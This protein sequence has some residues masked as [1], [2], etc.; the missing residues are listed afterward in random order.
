MMRVLVSACLLGDRVRYS[1]GDAKTDSPVLDRWLAEGRVVPFCPEVAGGLGVPRPPAEIRR[2]S[3]VGVL[4][5]AAVVVTAHGQDV[6][7]SFVRGA[8]LALERAA[9]DGVKLA[10]LKD[11]SPSC[12]SEAIYDGSF[13][14]RK[15]KGQGVTAALLEDHGIAV[16]TERAFAQADQYLL[17]LEAGDRA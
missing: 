9:A 4:R 17:D 3:G 2:G 7:A 14:G 8:A 6:T 15:H 13:T 12:G 5:G 11:G 16:F 1:G 10:V